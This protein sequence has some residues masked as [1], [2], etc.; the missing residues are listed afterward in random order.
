MCPEAKGY[1][2]TQ[3]V[4]V[5]V[6]AKFKNGGYVIIAKASYIVGQKLQCNALIIEDAAA[7]RR[8]EFMS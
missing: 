4:N 3:H 2:G 6:R 7:A 1:L 8:P 5:A